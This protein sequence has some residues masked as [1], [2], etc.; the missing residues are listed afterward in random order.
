MY[1]VFKELFKLFISNNL[2]IL[3]VIAFLFSYSLVPLVILL[4]RKLKLGARGGGRKIHR[5]VIPNIGGIA[6]IISFILSVVIWAP[7]FRFVPDLKS[8]VFI[9]GGSS[10]LILFFIGVRDDIIPMPALIKLLGQIIAAFVV[11]FFGGIYVSNFNGFMGYHE[12]PEIYAKVIAIF[13]I[14]SVINA[15]NLIDGI[16]GLASSLAIISA[17]FYATWFLLG[18]NIV[19]FTIS[20]ALIGALIGFLMFNKSPAKIFMG[21]TGSMFLGFTISILAIR[22]VDYNSTKPEAYYHLYNAPYIAMTTMLVP[23]ADVCRVFIDRLLAKKSPF[24]PDKTHIH[25]LLLKLGLSHNKVVIL[26]SSFSFI[27]I[28]IAVLLNKTFSSFFFL[29]VTLFY[30]TFIISIKYMIRGRINDIK[31]NARINN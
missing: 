16:D 31:K 2:Y 21:D 18:D 14:I 10:V 29:I 8:N 15:Y 20:F 30:I 11:V 17:S 4:S 12:I 26:L 7:N 1:S 19:M 24:F 27:F 25:H 28:L 5:N 3:V 9:F 13:L 23:I 22:F 6:I